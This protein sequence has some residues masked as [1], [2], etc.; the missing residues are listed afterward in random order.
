[1]VRAGIAQQIP[2]IPENGD[3]L[4]KFK[5]FPSNCFPTCFLECH[6]D[7]DPPGRL[8]GSSS[9][10]TTSTWSWRPPLDA[11]PSLGRGP[12]RERRSNRGL[13]GYSRAKFGHLRVLFCLE[14]IFF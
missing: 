1:M 9:A 10:V 11:R 14:R 5:E 8:C 2:A 4:G 7:R 12:D 13:G 3:T 6:L